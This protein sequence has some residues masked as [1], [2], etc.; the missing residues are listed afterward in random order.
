MIRFLRVDSIKYTMNKLSSIV[1]YLLALRLPLRPLVKIQ[2]CREL[3]WPRGILLDLRPCVWNAVSSNSHMGQ[4][5]LY[6]Q[7]GG[8]KLHP[9]INIIDSFIHPQEVLLAQFRLHVHL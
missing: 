7:K 6:V 9:V 3:P 2:Y 5:R 4:L 1:Y 8:L